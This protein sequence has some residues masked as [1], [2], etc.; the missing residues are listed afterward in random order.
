MLVMTGADRREQ[1]ETQSLRRQAFT[2]SLAHSV[3]IGLF[4]FEQ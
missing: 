4:T 2:H 3:A 1:D